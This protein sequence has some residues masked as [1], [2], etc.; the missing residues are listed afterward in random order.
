MPVLYF[1]PF[2]VVMSSLKCAVQGF[3]RE[4]HVT[5]IIVE[6]GF[7]LSRKISIHYKDISKE[8]LIEM[9]PLCSG[10]ANLIQNVPLSLS[11]L[12]RSV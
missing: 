12:S 5:N 10:S 6:H 7:F 9:A 3:V 8:Q 4:K 1:T 11:F 2:M